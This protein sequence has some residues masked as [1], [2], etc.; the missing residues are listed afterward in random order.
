MI[1]KQLSLT[2]PVLLTLSQ[3]LE[4]AQTA[5]IT[6][7]HFTRDATSDESSVDATSG[8]VHLEE[9][10]GYIEGGSDK[11]T[12]YFLETSGRDTVAERSA[13]GVESAARSLNLNVVYLMI[14]DR[15]DM[16]HP[17]TRELYNNY[18]IRFYRFSLEEL[19]KGEYW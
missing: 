18:D 4:I 14:T 15:L 9:Y 10:R 8:Y 7:E 1:A 6:R 2:L 13:C 12:I 3:S 11:D 16:S 17:L 5:I 19:V